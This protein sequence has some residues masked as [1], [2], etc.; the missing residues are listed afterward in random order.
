MN[1]HRT[2]EHG[3]PYFSSTVNTGATVRLKR[4]YLRA[5]KALLTSLLRELRAEHFLGRE[6]RPLYFWGSTVWPAHFQDPQTIMCCYFTPRFACL[7]S[8]TWRC[9]H[10]S[11]RK[12]KNALKTMFKDPNVDRVCSYSSLRSFQVAWQ[13]S[14]PHR[15]LKESLWHAKRVVQ[16]SNLK[17]CNMSK[18][19]ALLSCVSWSQYR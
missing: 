1:T 8:S 6:A 17:T 9:K 7:H 13:C 2:A 10:L 5:A 12:R 3:Q 14:F 18:R 4:Q 19:K 11:S 16:V 15:T